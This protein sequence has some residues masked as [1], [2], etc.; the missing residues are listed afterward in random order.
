MASRN[1]LSRFLFGIALFL[2]AIVL[3][4]LCVYAKAFREAKRILTVP[5]V[6]EEAVEEGASSQAYQIKKE[7]LPLPYKTISPSLNINAES[8][9]IIDTATS[10][11]LYEKNADTIIPPASMTKIVE[12]YVVL[13]E[14]EKGAISLDDIV[15]L[16][17]ESWVQN[18][19]S[20]ATR[21]NLEQGQIV[22]LR[23]LLLGLSIASANDASIAVAHYVCNSME[24]FVERMNKTVEDMGLKSTHFVESSGYSELNYTTARDF[25]IFAMNYINRFPYTLKEFHSQKFLAYP[26]PQNI[27]EGKVPYTVKQENTNKL[28]DTLQ[29]CDGLKTGFIYESGYNISVT[30]QRD[31]TRFLS[32]TMRGPGSNT[33]EGN[34]YRVEDNMT[35]FSYAFNSF[36]DYV[37]TEKHRFNLNVLGCRQKALSL[38]P[39]EDETLTVPFIEGNS[40][41]E[42]AE[43]IKITASIPR[44]VYGKVKKGEQLGT[45]TYSIGDTELKV[46][47]LVSD[48]DTQGA[49]GLEKLYDKLVLKIAETYSRAF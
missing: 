49:E 42:A 48:R 8:A 44:L 23:E 35:L 20:D 29:G 46:I 37:P 22:T 31:G 18:I 24:A 16:P 13:E 30:A 39:N 32:V 25:A 47:A 12:M 9:I 26:L 27:P 6:V 3:S 34:R 28:L 45:I 33:Q 19:P 10:C 14:V 7:L 38:V 1:K 17:K 2:F 4:S 5:P 36:A 43:S 15:P 40:P 41:K 21:M 11:I